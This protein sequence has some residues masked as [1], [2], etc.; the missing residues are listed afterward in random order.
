MFQTQ[1]KAMLKMLFAVVWALQ[2]ESYVVRMYKRPHNSGMSEN[3]VNS[4]II[5]PERPKEL[6]LKINTDLLEVASD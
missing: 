2:Q 6:D 1:L 5:P 3:D 4:E